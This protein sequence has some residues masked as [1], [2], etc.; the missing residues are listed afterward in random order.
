MVPV[1]ELQIGAVCTMALMIECLWQI[2]TGGE[3][4]PTR[5]SES[6]QA[7]SASRRDWALTTIVLAVNPS[8]L[9]QIGNPEHPVK[10]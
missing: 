5:G 10:I 3:T 7:K 8:L 1:Y 4:A 9:Y 2:V 6:E